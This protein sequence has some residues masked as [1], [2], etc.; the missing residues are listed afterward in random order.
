MSAAK[1]AP[2]PA[3][4]RADVERKLH[5]AEAA[6][7]GTTL[8]VVG[9]DDASL[10]DRA[11]KL[12]QRAKE[13]AKKA[14]RAAAD[15]A[16]RIAQAARTAAENEVDKQRKAAWWVVKKGAEATFVYAVM[17]FVIAYMVFTS[18]TGKRVTKEME[19]LLIAAALALL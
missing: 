18:D 12:L 17:P 10:L 13:K 7:S 5:Q 8:H 3:D 14:G 6:L 9:A 2:P 19:P 15:A 1:K 4:W 16:R 11:Q